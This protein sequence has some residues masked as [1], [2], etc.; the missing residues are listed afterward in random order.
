L[1][2]SPEPRAYT[3]EEMRAM[4][5]DHLRGLA[6]SVARDEGDCADRLDR[7]IFAILC[8]FD[9]VADGLPAFALTPQPHPDDAAFCR[10]EGQHWWPDDVDIADGPRHLHEMWAKKDWGNR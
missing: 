7:L 5:L 10:D 9:G 8:V 3:A 6:A 4:F 1:S 2:A